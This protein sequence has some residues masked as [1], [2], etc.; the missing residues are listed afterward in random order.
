MQLYPAAERWLLYPPFLCASSFCLGEPPP[1]PPLCPRR[2]F[3]LGETL[4][5]VDLSLMVKS[6]VQ[7][8]LWGGR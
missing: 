7:Y 4:A 6:G 5:L 3:Y 1:P 8:S 2:Y